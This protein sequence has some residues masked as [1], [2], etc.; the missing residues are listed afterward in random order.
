MA[1][2]I[3]RPVSGQ[4]LRAGWGA[5]VA[6]R[7]NA[8]GAFASPGTLVREGAGGSTAA[9]VP[10]NQRNRRG[11]A[12]QPLP[13]EVR[14]D[15]TL[16]ENQGGLKIFLEGSKLVALDDT[17]VATN[18]FTGVEAVQ[19]QPGWY[20]LSD[21]D[22]QSDTAVY[23]TLTASATPQ[24]ALTNGPAAQSAAGADVYSICIAQFSYTPA[25]S[26]APATCTVTQQTVG[27]LYIGKG[28]AKAV[29]APFDYTETTTTGAGGQPETV[30]YLARCMFYFDG[31][32]QTLPDYTA[33]PLPAGTVYLVGTGVKNSE[34]DA[35]DWTFALQNQPGAASTGSKVLNLKLYDFAGGKP[36]VDYRTT[37]LAVNAAPSFG[38]KTFTFDGVAVAKILADDDIDVGQKTLKAG[39]GVTLAV[40]QDGK[41][42]TISAPGAG[43]AS[44]S[45]WT[46]TRTILG[47]TVYDQSSHAL[48]RRYITET[49]LNGVMVS[50]T[51]GAW[52]TYHTAVQETI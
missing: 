7:L 35:Y 29:P 43:S 2:M 36:S 47:D 16:N 14:F 49:W 48:R 28:A 32:L 30:K 6:D 18:A 20:G 1:A 3:E 50:Q 21:V 5:E 8:A 9:P 11:G 25:S 46:G 51:P 40:S 33:L 41:T 24:V 22:L 38:E 17:Y 19:E 12:A 44:T 4:E 10:A 39:E 52:E 45:G 13:F 42:I 31:A 27:A 37:F 23:L 15:Q 26:G 34:T